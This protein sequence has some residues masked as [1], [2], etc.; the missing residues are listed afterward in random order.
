M[1]VP[2]EYSSRP[3]AVTIQPLQAIVRIERKVIEVAKSLLRL[4]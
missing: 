2:L 3:S 1:K 4:D